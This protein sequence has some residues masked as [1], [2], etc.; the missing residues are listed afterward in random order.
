MYDIHICTIYHPVNQQQPQ[1][2]SRELQSSDKMIFHCR[3]YP[4]LL[5][6]IAMENHDFSWENPLFL[7]PFTR[8]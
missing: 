3:G 7:W 8:G 6:N 2:G 5:T 4:V 1:F